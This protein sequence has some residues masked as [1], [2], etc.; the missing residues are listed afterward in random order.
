[1]L[2]ILKMI[3]SKEDKTIM[4]MDDLRT[5]YLPIQISAT[6]PVSGSTKVV[7]GIEYDLFLNCHNMEMLRKVFH[8][9]T[10]TAPFSNFTGCLYLQ[11]IF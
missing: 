5:L 9:M 11:N 2:V 1:M 6:I 3:S 7:T 10:T 4:Y 8:T